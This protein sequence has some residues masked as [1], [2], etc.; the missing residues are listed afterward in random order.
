[1]KNT[2]VIFGLD[3]AGV[4]GR[5]MPKSIWTDYVQ[6]PQIILKRY[7]L[8]TLAVNVMFVN[9]LP[10]LVSVAQDLSLITAKFTPTRTAKALTSRIEQICHLYTC[11][12]FA[13]GTVLMDNKF[14]KLYPF[15]LSWPSIQQLQRSMFPRLSG[16]SASSRRGG[17][18]F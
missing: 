17:E 1:V 9:N 12:S 3:P 5:T 7:Q 8:V 10:F 2:N 11:G 14:K 18:E 16:R 15:V 13:I 4:R 6:I